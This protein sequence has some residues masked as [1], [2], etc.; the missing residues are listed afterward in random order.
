MMTRLSAVGLAA[1]LGLGV[2]GT[3]FADSA[4]ER[5]EQTYAFSAGQQLTLTNTNG[6]VAIESWDRDEVLVRATKRV[7]T[8]SGSADRALEEL[9]IE[10]D[11]HGGGIEIETVY[12]GWRKMFGWSDVS[13]SVEYELRVPRRADLELRTVNGEIDVSG[14]AGEIRLRSTNGE[15]SVTDS[16]GSVSA[17]TTNGGIQVELDEVSASGMEFQTTN[18]GIRVHLPPTV[19]TSLRARTTNGSIETDFPVEVRGTIR[20]NRL[21]GDING[22]G[23]EIELLTTNGSIQIRER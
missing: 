23:P 9:R 7:R 20:R 17:S 14:V 10:V 12:P 2:A 8:R 15:I 3:A 1:T 13:A 19:R 22:G 21:E 5:F 16:A 4:H 11:V 6:D 18:G